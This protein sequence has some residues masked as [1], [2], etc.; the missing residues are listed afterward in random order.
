M[1]ALSSDGQEEAT[2]NSQHPPTGTKSLDEVDRGDR[3][4]K[5]CA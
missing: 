2:L 5:I 1:F 3:I 4:K